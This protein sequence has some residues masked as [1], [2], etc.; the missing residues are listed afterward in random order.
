M[1]KAAAAKIEKIAARF[2]RSHYLLTVTGKPMRVEGDEA[3]LWIIDWEVRENDVLIAATTTDAKATIADIAAVLENLIK[4]ARDQKEAQKAV[5]RE[6]ARNRAATPEEKRAFENLLQRVDWAIK[7]YAKAADKMRSDI[8][9]GRAISSHTFEELL[10]AEAERKVALWINNCLMRD[11]SIVATLEDVVELCDR[12]TSFYRPNNS[13]SFAH[14]AINDI[15]H[16]TFLK[17]GRIAR[18]RAEY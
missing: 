3:K 7:S 1:T 4:A 8:N 5:A 17:M 12:E 18:L 9:E 16:V 10:G 14:N 15:E 2:K 11:C 6:A 13:S